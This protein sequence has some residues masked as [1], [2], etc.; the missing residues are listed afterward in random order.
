MDDR[1]KSIRELEDAKRA[2]KEE[3]DRLL[4][5]LGN[6]LISRIG[7]SEPFEK[8]DVTHMGSSPA[9]VL[10]EYRTLQGEI[11]QSEDMIKSLEAD[12]LRLK[13]LEGTIAQKEEEEGRLTKELEEAQLELG[14]A[15]LEASDPMVD[16]MPNSPK[17]QENMFLAKITEQENRL[18]ELEEREGGIFAW[19]GKN[20][21]MA[22]A[23]GLLLKNRSGLQRLYRSVGEHFV[24]AGQGSAMGWELTQRAVELKGTLST[25]AVDLAVL[26]GER[27]NIGDL[28][29]AEGSP[30]RRIQGLQKH[31]DQVK[32]EFP[33][34]CL[35]FAS[36]ALEKEGRDSLSAL[37]TEEDKPALEAA[38]ALNERMAEKDEEIARI[39][40]AI[41]VDELMAAIEKMRKGISTQEQRIGEAQAQ[42]ASYEK[43]ISETQGQIEELQK[44]I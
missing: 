24:S 25:L 1:N 14:Q 34:V 44:F 36:L 39:Q 2:H 27:R 42:I 3:R 19:L 5:G 16:Q 43:Q 13:E 23:K 26:K 7:D 6:S 40:R 37:I 21:Q 30:A 29:G 38:A 4:E 20:A 11:T 8:T 18:I 33:G 31:I 32:G 28:F 41:K 9:K 10:T 15:L 12:V 22:V 35:R 17:I